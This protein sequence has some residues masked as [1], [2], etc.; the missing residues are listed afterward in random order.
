MQMSRRMSNG[1]QRLMA[2]GVP[3]MFHSPVLLETTISTSMLLTAP[4]K[5]L[6]LIMFLRNVRNG[7]KFYFSTY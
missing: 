5:Y 7:K 3:R 2:S 1:K 4:I 6:A